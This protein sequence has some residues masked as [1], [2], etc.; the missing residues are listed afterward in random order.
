[1]LEEL[2]SVCKVKLMTSA[3]DYCSPWKHKKC[4]LYSSGLL[5]EFNATTENLIII[6]YRAFEVLRKS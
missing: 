4:Y 6:N 3:W 5:S 1:M 2:V